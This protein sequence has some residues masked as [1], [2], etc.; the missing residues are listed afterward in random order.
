MLGQESKY[1]KDCYNGNFIGIDYQII[2]DLT[3][4]LPDNW[5]EFNEKYIPIYLSNHPGKS[6]VAA[7][8]ACGFIWTISKGVQNGDIILSPDGWG[9]YYVG[10]VVDNYSYHAEEILPHRR[11]M[12]WYTKMIDRTE[13]S[14]AL[15]GSTGTGNTVTNITRHAQEIEN[16][17]SNI[18][19]PIISVADE[20]V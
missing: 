7:G 18:R 5:R 20:S 10:E 8:L 3:G 4:K 2:E 13:M 19:P 17:I 1:A 15:K 11:I 12:K 6:K 14:E 16:L 9:K